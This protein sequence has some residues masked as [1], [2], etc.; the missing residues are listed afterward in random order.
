MY[1]E[2]LLSNQSICN[3]CDNYIMSML[4]RVTW[5]YLEL[6]LFTTNGS[7]GLLAKLYFG[8]KALKS[9][10]F[11]R[12][13]HLSC[14]AAQSACRW[15]S[16]NFQK[17]DGVITVVATSSS[18][19]S[20]RASI[21]QLVLMVK[22]KSLTNSNKKQRS[23]L[24]YHTM[25]VG[26]CCQDIAVIETKPTHSTEGLEWHAPQHPA[27]TFLPENNTIWTCLYYKFL[28]KYITFL[29]INHFIYSK[30]NEYIIWI[31]SI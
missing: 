1:L 30:W 22:K 13:L 20:M 4:H 5:I 3:Y 10:S 2:K 6:L 18:I 7:K 23:T 26:I 27:S 16:M 31:H 19:Q 9:A 29:K 8:E 14:A 11:F 24:I 12:A 21:I 17:G 15:K 25:A 28:K